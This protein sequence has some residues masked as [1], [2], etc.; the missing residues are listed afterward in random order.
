MS[1]PLVSSMYHTSCILIATH[2]S[3]IGWERAIVVQFKHYHGYIYCTSLTRDF[4]NTLTT[5]PLILPLR[6]GVYKKINRSAG[7]AV[8][9]REDPVLFYI[10]AEMKDK[11]PPPAYIHLGLSRLSISIQISIRS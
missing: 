1:K 2:F 5:Q 7:R 9:Q 6:A 11:T 10:P 3:H 8:K 4:A